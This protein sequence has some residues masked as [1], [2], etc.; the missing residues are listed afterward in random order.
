MLAFAPKELALLM[1]MMTGD[2]AIVQAQLKRL[3]FCKLN[4]LQE[5]LMKSRW[6]SCMQ[7][8]F[9][10]LE[11][12][13]CHSQGSII[14]INRTWRSDGILWYVCCFRITAVVSHMLAIEQLTDTFMSIVT[15]ISVP[16]T[17]LRFDQVFTCKQ[18]CVSFL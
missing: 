10:Y 16:C 6:L 12:G 11:P 8:A 2:A 3:N 15:L 1:Y 18:H 5:M 9:L 4:N 14:Y 7:Q 13:D 17:V